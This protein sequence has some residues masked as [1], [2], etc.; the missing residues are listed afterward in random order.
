MKCCTLLSVAAIIASC[1]SLS[2]TANAQEVEASSKVSTESDITVE[3]I[4][5]LITGK[6]WEEAASA[7]DQFATE[8]KDGTTTQS[9]NIELAAKVFVAQPKLA[10]ERLNTVVD[11]YCNKK[12]LSQE[13]AMRLASTT[14][15]LASVLPRAS[16]PNSTGNEP[17]SIVVN[18]AL[19]TVLKVSKPHIP[20][21]RALQWQLSKAHYTEGKVDEGWRILEDAC[22]SAIKDLENGDLKG[23]EMATQMLSAVSPFRIQRKDGV[24]S[25]L[26]AA[27]N[28]FAAKLEKG[29]GTLD[30]LSGF[31]SLLSSK[32]SANV[33]TDPSLGTSYL[34]R[35]TAA[36]ERF[37]ST[38]HPTN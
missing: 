23:K 19:D 11:Y 13:E 10:K 33:Y 25:L 2:E 16:L 6:K 36:V 12:D 7:I 14:S 31:S 29:N 26:S 9:L 27:E 1:S 34:E 38:H 8:S 15:N 28:H 32:I 37:E 30:D 21:V 4:R 24:E 18:R 20:A 22:R 3:R 17:V 35:L 5:E